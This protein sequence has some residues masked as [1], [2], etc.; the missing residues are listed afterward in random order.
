MCRQG[1]MSVHERLRKAV[2]ALVGGGDVSHLRI[3]K[4]GNMQ[5]SQHSTGEHLS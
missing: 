1:S 2:V 3:G 4:A 5:L